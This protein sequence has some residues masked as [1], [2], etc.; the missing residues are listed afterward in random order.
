MQKY[1]PNPNRYIDGT[2]RNLTGGFQFTK[3]GN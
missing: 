3:Y 1:G 2:L